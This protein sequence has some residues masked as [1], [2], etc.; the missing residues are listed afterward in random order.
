[1]T[2]QRRWLRLSRRH[3]I[4]SGHEQEGPGAGNHS[5]GLLHPSGLD[6]KIAAKEG[7]ATEEADSN[8]STAREMARIS[9]RH[10][11]TILSVWI[12]LKKFHVLAGNDGSKKYRVSN[13]N[14]LLPRQAA[15][16]RRQNGV[17]LPCRALSCHHVQSR[18]K[19]FPHRRAWQP[20][21]LRRHP[22][23][24]SGRAEGEYPE[25]DQESACGSCWSGGLQIRGE[26]G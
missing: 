11:P 23:H 2:A 26:G 7:E 12:C 16:S 13:T 22:A 5:H 25:F 19:Q 17:Y 20:G 8:L 4:S 3:P 10:S 21:P 24:L 14:K 1:M 9:Q 15:L 6:R 18:P